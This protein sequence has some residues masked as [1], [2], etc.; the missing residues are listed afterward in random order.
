MMLSPT[1][2]FGHLTL[3]RLLLQRGMAAIYLLA[4]L[5]VLLQAK[6]LIGVRGLLPIPDFVE[7]T[8]FRRAPSLFH[9]RYSDGLL[10][11]VSWTGLL[12]SVC[13]LLGLT[14]AGPLWLSIAS[15]LVLYILYLSVVNVGQN[16]FGFGWESMLLEA[17]F[18]AAFLGSRHTAPSVIPILILRWMFSVP[19]LAQA[20]SNSDMTPAG[21]IYVPLLSL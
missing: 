20:S 8:T 17:G 1:A 10:D 9:W 18:F 2:Y 16:F 11:L 14:E 4:F 21:V 6:P 12:I 3:T 13:A 19:S 15:W 5:T 7:H